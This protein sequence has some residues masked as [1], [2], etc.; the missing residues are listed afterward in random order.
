MDP[1][2][3]DDAIQQLLDK[4]EIREV[5]Y[6]YCRGAD[7]MDAELMRSAYHDDAVDDHGAIRGGRDDYVETVMRVL[8]QNYLSTSHAI[9]NQLI[10]LTGDHAHVESYFVAV[11]THEP[12]GILTQDT[13]YGRYVD[14]FEH[15]GGRWGIVHRTVVIDSYNSDAV[16]PW[17]LYSD[18][19]LM[20]RGRRDH[21]DVSYRRLDQDSR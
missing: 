15:R 6:R 2:R 10:E 11:H 5:I 18:I 3:R 17:R 9:G 20:E 8:E 14:R 4:Q 16:R 7:R 19:S 12:D 13:V 21:S 1:H